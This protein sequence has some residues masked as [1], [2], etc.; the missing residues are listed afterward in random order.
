[1][2]TFVPTSICMLEQHFKCNM[3]RFKKQH[4]LLIVIIHST[5]KLLLG[6]FSPNS[7]TF[8]IFSCPNVASFAITKVVKV[9]LNRRLFARNFSQYLTSTVDQILHYLCGGFYRNCTNNN[10]K[11]ILYQ[12]MAKMMAVK[13]VFYF[14]VYRI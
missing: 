2:E 7:L 10:N 12:P 6:T 4:F 11:Y 5:A 1:M 13:N 9:F 8:K 14:C 3:H